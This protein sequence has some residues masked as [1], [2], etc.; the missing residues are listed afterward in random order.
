MVESVLSLTI[1]FIIGTGFFGGSGYLILQYPLELARIDEKLSRLEQFVSELQDYMKVLD[2]AVS[3]LYMQDTS[4][5]LYSDILN[6]IVDSLTLSQ[7]EPTFKESILNWCSESVRR[8]SDKR[9]VVAGMITYDEFTSE[10]RSKILAVYDVNIEFVLDIE[11]LAANWNGN[12]KPNK[13]E[14]VSMIRHNL[15]LVSIQNT[16]LRS[17]LDQAEKH[18]NRLI[19]IESRAIRA[20]NSGLARKAYLALI[21]LAM[22]LLIY[23]LLVYSLVTR[24]IKQK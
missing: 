9:S 13:L 11:R 17:F 19:E 15:Q 16:E 14:R 5:N 21:G 3:S 23:M 20:S 18:F 10:F 4:R 2:D 24:S 8:L 22:G 1:A 12:D 6:S 7:L